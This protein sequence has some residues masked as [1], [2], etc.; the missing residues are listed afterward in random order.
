MTDPRDL[1]ILLRDIDVLIE[2]E[3]GLLAERALEF[4]GLAEDAD[5]RRERILDLAAVMKLDGRDPVL[6]NIISC[7]KPYEEDGKILDSAWAVGDTVRELEMLRARLLKADEKPLE[8]K[9]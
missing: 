6:D 4:V 1:D 3:R 9:G 7:Y 2:E 8:G 5:D